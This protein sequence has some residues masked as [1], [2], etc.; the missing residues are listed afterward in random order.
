MTTPPA[1]SGPSAP[2]RALVN[3]IQPPEPA[4][5]RKS[6]LTALMIIRA[7]LVAVLL[8]VIVGF[9]LVNGEYICL[10]RSPWWGPPENPDVYT[11]CSGHIDEM[12]RNR[13]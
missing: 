1:T 6:P 3:P 11:S 4:K 13:S 12:L 8:M 10:D 9:G 7:V 2:D 5:K